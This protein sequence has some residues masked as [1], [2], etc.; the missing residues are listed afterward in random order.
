MSA[1]R[2][3]VALAAAVTLGLA[4]AAPLAA[5]QV[6]LTAAGEYGIRHLLTVAQPDSGRP[7]REGLGYPAF[8]DFREILP[9]E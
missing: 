3:R 2:N 5:K 6:V 1:I 7:P 4:L 8:T 9:D